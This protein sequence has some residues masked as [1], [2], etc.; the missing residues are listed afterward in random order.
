MVLKELKKSWTF[1]KGARYEVGDQVLIMYGGWLKLPRKIAVI[2]WNNHGGYY[3]YAL[4]GVNDALFR[5]SDLMPAEL[6]KIK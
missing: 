3:F 4:K 5:D 2:G 1:H 6:G